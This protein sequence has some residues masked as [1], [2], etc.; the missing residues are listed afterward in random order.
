MM[1]TL[2]T[3]SSYGLNATR[4]RMTYMTL[5]LFYMYFIFHSCANVCN[6]M[7]QIHCLGDIT[8]LPTSC[9]LYWMV[10]VDRRGNVKFATTTTPCLRRL[11]T[12]KTTSCMVEEDNL[13]LNVPQWTFK[14]KHTQELI[15]SVSVQLHNTACEP[16]KTLVTCIAASLKSQWKRA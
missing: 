11:R 9:T 7:V 5:F 1:I 12:G 6:F 8:N 4:E 16:L 2:Q 3:L 15:A 14:L 13:S 10:K